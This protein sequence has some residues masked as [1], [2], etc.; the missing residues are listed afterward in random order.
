MKLNPPKTMTIHVHAW[1][2][3]NVTM[4][5]PRRHI[6]AG[7]GGFDWY[8]DKAAPSCTKAF[9]DGFHSLISA[10]PDNTGDFYFTVEVDAR[11]LG[12]VQAITDLIDRDLIDLCAK[13]KVRRIGANVLEYWRRGKFKMG[14]AKRPAKAA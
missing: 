8:L 14:G 2:Y 5:F 3:V 1:E 12:N 4:A 13:A 6:D 7:G 9:K 11:L 10:D